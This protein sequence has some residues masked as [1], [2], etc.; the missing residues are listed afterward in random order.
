MTPG[1]DIVKE[2]II[3]YLESEGHD[4]LAAAV[5]DTPLKPVPFRATLDAEDRTR[6]EEASMAYLK[7]RGLR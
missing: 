3:R 4:Q 2:W 7:M 6:F 1:E 5:R